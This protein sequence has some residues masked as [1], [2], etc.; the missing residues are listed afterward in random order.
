MSNPG[1]SIT[2]IRYNGFNLSHTTAVLRVVRFR[3]PCES[4][5]TPKSSTKI[6]IIFYLQ[7]VA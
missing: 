6:R 1:L 4:V 5:S 2:R 3:N 7:P